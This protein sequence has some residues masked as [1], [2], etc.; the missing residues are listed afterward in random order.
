MWS[1]IDCHQL[2]QFKKINIG[3]WIHRLPDEQFLHAVMSYGGNAHEIIENQE[4]FDLFLPV[5]PADFKISETYCHQE[6]KD[7]IACDITI[8]NGRND[9]SAIMYDMCEWRYYAVGQRLFIR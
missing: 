1:H 7:K 4:L 8:I 3:I 2:K 9:H 5:L 6:K